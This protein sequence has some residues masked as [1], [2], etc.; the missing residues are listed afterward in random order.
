MNIMTKRDVSEYCKNER[1]NVDTLK[2]KLRKFNC[3]ILYVTIHI[4][5]QKNILLN[6]IVYL[7]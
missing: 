4:L 2:R 5:I 3:W 6:H 7:V 1:Y